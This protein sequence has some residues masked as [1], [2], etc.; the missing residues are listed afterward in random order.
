MHAGARIIAVVVALVTPGL[1]CSCRR[2]ERGF[3]VSPPSAKTLETVRARELQPGPSRNEM[4]GPT[5]PDKTHSPETNAGVLSTP[6]QNEYEENAYALSEGQRLFSSFNCV[7]C[8]AH[9]G[10]GM[11]PALMD[12]KWIYGHDPA[13]IFAT[14]V[15]G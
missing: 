6:V 5:F 7:G 8:H 4:G 2:E 13:Q 9:G 11:G 12:S 3:R 15:E 10:G 14:I 1:L